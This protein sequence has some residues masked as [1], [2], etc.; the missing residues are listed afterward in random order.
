MNKIVGAMRFFLTLKMHTS[1]KQGYGNCNLS[2]IKLTLEFG[3]Y[4][5]KQGILC[6]KN[7]GNMHQ[8]FFSVKIILFQMHIVFSWCMKF[9]NFSILYFIA[10]KYSKSFVFT[11]EYNFM[12]NFTYPNIEI[13]Y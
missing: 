2:C 11:G 1:N 8:L 3:F 6:K 5:A 9:E 12:E 10:V 13:L 4:N 7:P